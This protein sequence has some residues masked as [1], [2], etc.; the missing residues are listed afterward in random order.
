MNDDLISRD[1][2]LDA[3]SQSINILDAMS[4]IEDL[5][6]VHAEPITHESAIDFLNKEGW[7]QEHDRILSGC[8]DCGT[9]N[10]AT[11]AYFDGQR[12]AEEYVYM[13]MIE[14]IKA[15]F[16]QIDAASAFKVWG[17]NEIIDVID[18]HISGKEQA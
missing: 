17:Y 5:P 12:Y 10:V 9:C 14:D 3:C 15:E 8:D 16:R 2:V 11:K 4:R 6:S 7:M 13:P 18:R 1:A